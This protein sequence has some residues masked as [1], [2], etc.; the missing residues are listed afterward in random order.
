MSNDNQVNVPQSSLWQSPLSPFIPLQFIGKY[1]LSKFGS[2]LLMASASKYPSLA[3]MIIKTLLSFLNC[4][5][6]VTRHET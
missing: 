4:V 1:G 3:S 6:S 2:R 5:R